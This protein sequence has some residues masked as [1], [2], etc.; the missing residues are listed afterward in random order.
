MEIR[1]NEQYNE[2]FT[3]LGDSGD[4]ISIDLDFSSEDTRNLS[5]EL[6]IINLY[7]ADSVSPLDLG[8]TSIFNN[9]TYISGNTSPWG[10]LITGSG[11][12]GSAG[13]ILGAGGGGSGSV[14]T[15]HSYNWNQ[16]NWNSIG[17]GVGQIS[18]G[19][20]HV[21]GDAKFDGD[22]KI[23]GK[24]ILESLEKIEE[25]LAIFRP[26]EELEKKWDKLR[27]LRNQYVEMEKDIIEKEK[28]WETLK[29]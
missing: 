5:D 9:T 27:E 15:G 14:T 10:N 24:S 18:P 16:T 23:K 29:K 28:I 1:Q 19:E 2:I 12:G 25:K 21:Q 26:N 8:L 11:G 3:I 6:K 17:T 13:A 20:L 22:I 7:D 4:S